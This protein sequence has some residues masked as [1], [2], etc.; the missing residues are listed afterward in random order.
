MRPLFLCTYFFRRSFL[1]FATRYRTFASSGAQRRLF[2]LTRR[3]PT[4]RP[5]SF[6]ISKSST[7]VVISHP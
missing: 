6:T 7:P 2:G 1:R 3:L 4:T 5:F